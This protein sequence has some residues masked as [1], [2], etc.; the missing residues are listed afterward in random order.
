[1]DNLKDCIGLIM[2]GATLLVAVVI[3]LTSKNSKL[4][5]ALL[6]HEKDDVERFG[7]IGKILAVLNSKMDITIKNLTNDL[8]HIDQKINT[9][10]EKID[11][12]DKSLAVHIALDSNNKTNER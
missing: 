9:L 10:C 1:M 7:G 2:S 4:K 8:P 5:E 3:F 11:K 6:V 12:M